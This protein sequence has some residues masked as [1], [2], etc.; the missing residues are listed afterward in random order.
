M[1]VQEHKFFK[2]IYGVITLNYCKN[3]TYFKQESLLEILQNAKMND[4]KS[5]LYLINRTM[6]KK[7]V[8]KEF[9]KTNLGEF[10]PNQWLEMLMEF[11]NTVGE[12]KLLEEI[13]K[14]V[15]PH[16]VWLKTQEEVDEYSIQCL[17]SGAYMYWEGF[18][19]KRIPTHKVFIFE[20]SDLL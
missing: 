9:Y 12:N 7:T 15:K 20:R 4:S 13:K 17:A 5:M 6:S 1:Y 14:H 8:F 11:I 19:D 2:L 10:L 16:C 3:K 18:Q